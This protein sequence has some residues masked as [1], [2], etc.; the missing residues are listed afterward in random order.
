MDYSSL[1]K[2]PSEAKHSVLGPGL[3]TITTLAKFTDKMCVALLQYHGAQQTGI[4]IAIELRG[5][6]E[7]LAAPKKEGEYLRC[8]DLMEQEPE[9]SR[10]D[11]PAAEEYGAC[12]SESYRVSKDHPTLQ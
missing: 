12:E 9:V 6:Q 10:R 4:G 11:W 7:D 2:I 8:K 3:V 1:R 5:H